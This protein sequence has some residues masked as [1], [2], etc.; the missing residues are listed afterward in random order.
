[1]VIRKYLKKKYV[2][3]IHLEANFNLIDVFFLIFDKTFD[4]PF[5][6]Q[7]SL[8]WLFRSYKYQLSKYASG[9]RYFKNDYD[10]YLFSVIIYIF[11][12]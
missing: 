10:I 2:S 11:G 4:I 3:S 9:Y 6:K 5:E 1:M 8:F 7:L 12:R